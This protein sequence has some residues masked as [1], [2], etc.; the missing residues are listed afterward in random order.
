M[1]FR[2]L[3]G[4]L[5]NKTVGLT[6][7]FHCIAQLTIDIQFSIK[8]TAQNYSERHFWLTNIRSKT[9]LFVLDNVYR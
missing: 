2:L 3:T 5:F 1:S 6:D 7:L 9:V 4:S 8:K